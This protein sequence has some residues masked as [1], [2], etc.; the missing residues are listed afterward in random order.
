MVCACIRTPISECTYI[1]CFT[2]S[3]LALAM[4]PVIPLT[5]GVNTYVHMHTNIYIHEFI[6]Y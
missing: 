1:N 3:S 2:C 5:P 6:Y 4:A